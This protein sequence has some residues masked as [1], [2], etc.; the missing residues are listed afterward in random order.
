[1]PMSDEE[2]TPLRKQIFDWIG[3]GIISCTSLFMFYSLLVNIIFHS[4]KDYN[5]YGE[6][7]A[8]CPKWVESQK[9]DPENIN[10]VIFES[11]LR[12]YMSGAAYYGPELKESE[13][14]KIVSWVTN[15]CQENPLEN[16]HEAS[17][18]LNKELRKNPDWAEWSLRL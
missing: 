16:V 9:E 3:V 18:A 17:D 6:G 1:M 11:W 15:Y 2:K 8:S 13:T 7:T 10:R 12:G 4:D 5:V 14:E